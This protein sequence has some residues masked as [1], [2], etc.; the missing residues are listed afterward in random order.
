MK[1]SIH[2]WV[3]RIL[4]SV[5]VFLIVLVLVVPHLMDVE[6]PLIFK[7]LLKPAKIAIDYIGSFLPRPNIGTEENPIYEGTPIDLLVGFTLIFFNVLL[8]PIVTYLLLSLMSKVLGQKSNA[9]DNL[10]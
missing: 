10:N 6:P 5:I 2:N 3:I 7:I 1:F 9:E 4:V 8:Y